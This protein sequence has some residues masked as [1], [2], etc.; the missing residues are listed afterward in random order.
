[1][2]RLRAAGL[3]LLMGLGLL[4]L[5]LPGLVAAVAELPGRPVLEALEAGHTP[6]PAALHRLADSAARAHRPKA[7]AAARLAL[8]D[9]A[10]A[11]AALERGL[12]A[13]PADPYAWTQLAY[14]RHRLGDAAG[15]AQAVAA[16]LAAGPWEREI[17]FERL[18]VAAPLFPHLDAPTRAAMLDQLAWTW[19]LDRPRLVATVPPDAFW[20]L[21]RRALAGQPE[22]LTKAAGH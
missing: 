12:A 1:M 7:E 2:E 13:S 10:G 8:D 22:A 17:A 11:A 4:G 3:P 15:A 9:M 16:A 5:G 19:R 21:Y 18:A 20:P 14:T 6:D